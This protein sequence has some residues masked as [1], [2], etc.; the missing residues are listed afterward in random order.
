[1]Y[2]SNSFVGLTYPAQG[3]ATFQEEKKT[4]LHL[5][6]HKLSPEFIK[7]FPVDVSNS[8]VGLTYPAQGAATFQEEKSPLLHLSRH[9][10][11][12]E[13]VSNSFVGFI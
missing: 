6:R 2:V 11:S 12:P 8:F 3:E 7:L 1:V 9:K 10:L 4:L 13:D 5:S